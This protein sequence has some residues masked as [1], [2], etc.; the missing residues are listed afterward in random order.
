MNGSESTQIARPRGRLIHAL[1][2]ISA[3]LLL[4]AAP[5]G[6][7][8]SGGGYDLHWN[9]QDAGAS[10]ASGANGY[11]LSG[12]VAQPDAKADGAMTNSGL[13]LRGGFWPGAHAGADTIFGNG[14]EPK[15]E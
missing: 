10:S 2:C 7:A 11:T 5:I 14:F 3:W 6:I 12:T 8:Q 1:L 4:T 15:L 9:T 13:I